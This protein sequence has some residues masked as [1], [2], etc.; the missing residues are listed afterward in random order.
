VIS[1]ADYQS[2]RESL[3]IS[4]IADT[5]GYEPLFRVTMDDIPFEGS[6]PSSPWRLIARQILG[7]RGGKRDTRYVAGSTCMELSSSVIRY[8][9]E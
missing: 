5:G 9:S 6:S 2:F 1:T 3:D 7:V 4:D 8:H